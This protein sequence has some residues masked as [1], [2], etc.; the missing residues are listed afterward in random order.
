MSGDRERCM[1]AGMDGYVTKPIRFQDIVSEM[2]RLQITAG[3]LDLA[4]T[5][6]LGLVS[7][8]ISS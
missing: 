5:P 2:N 8:A 6:Y 4:G 7:D 3:P 1:Q